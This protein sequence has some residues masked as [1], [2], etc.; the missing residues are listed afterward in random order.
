MDKFSNQLPYLLIPAYQPDKKLLFL[1]ESYKTLAPNQT[2]IIINDG[3][4]VK[5]NKIFSKAAKL[6]C[7]VLQHTHNQGKGAALKTGMSYWLQH[8]PAES[9]GVVTADA[10]GQHTAQNIFEINQKLIEHN[11]HL[12]LGVR[13]TAGKQ[14]PLRSAFGNSFTKALFN[15]AMH[16]DILDTQTGL[17]G[18]PRHLVTLMLESSASGY[19]FEFEMLFVTIQHDILIQQ[20]PI[21]TIYIENNADSHYRPLL[22]SLSIY[23]VFI[24]FCA[25]SI[26]SFV[27]DYLTFSTLYF[28]THQLALS[29]YG[30]R[31]LSGTFN[32]ILNKKK[33]FKHK[34]GTTTSLLRYIFLT[35]LIT[36]GSFLLLKLLVHIKVNAYLGKILTDCLLFIFSFTTQKFFIFNSANNKKR[37]I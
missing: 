26:S 5:Y 7:V 28:S 35:L 29:V 10:D 9:A 1:L 12:H 25:I 15:R 23:A 20:H 17:R 4:S 30:A 34:K 36:T 8:A 37:R 33:V 19:Q 32:F 31:T 11:N 3:S 16:S 2:F 6:G 14:I 18:I 27:L 21:K 13:N 24:R 22:D